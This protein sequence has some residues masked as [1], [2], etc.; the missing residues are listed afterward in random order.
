MTCGICQKRR[1]LV[2][3]WGLCSGCGDMIRGLWANRLRLKR[4]LKEAARG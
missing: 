1:G 2:F 3:R 4:A